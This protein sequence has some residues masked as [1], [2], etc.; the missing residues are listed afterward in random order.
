[1]VHEFVVKPVSAAPEPRA[2]VK[3]T[4]SG[5]R[6]IEVEGSPVVG[7]NTVAVHF[8]DQAVH[9]NFVGHDVHLVQ[10]EDDTDLEELATW[11]DWREPEGLEDPPPAE[12]MGGIHEMP[13]GQT[14]YF[15]VTL[16]P[17]RYAWIA[18]VPGPQEKGMLK[19]FTVSK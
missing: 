9:E 17:G 19:T 15:T 2:E 6:G 10:L 8:E 5:E 11:M 3:I 7:Q 1:M 13:A 14:G 16:E 18:E 12:F 4:L